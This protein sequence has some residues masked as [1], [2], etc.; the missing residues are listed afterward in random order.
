MSEL[1]MLR[2]SLGL[3][4]MVR[5]AQ[6]QGLGR[7]ESDL[8]Y[9]VHCQLG[10]LFGT[11]APSLFRVHEGEGRRTQVLAY[12]KVSAAALREHAQAFADPEAHENCDWDSFA[13]KALPERFEAGRGLGF[14]VRVCPTKRMSAEG[15][16]HRKGAEVD[17]FLAECWKAG[18]GTSV[19]RE[20]VY[21][22]WLATE[23]GRGDAARL[24]QAKLESFRRRRLTRRTQGEERKAVSVERPD[25]LMSGLLE[26]SEPGAF[27]ALL[28]R[29]LGRHRGFGY[30]ML[31]L[32]SGD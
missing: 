29:G 5:R 32:R 7:G 9:L 30:G 19:D 31:L 26:V 6:R 2:L 11:K 8:G 27:S 15:P 3:P 20:E 16:K 1:N 28:A 12:S 24:L 18:E 25:V 4:R 10:E 21:R 22:Q 17:V 13:G 23:L 14:E